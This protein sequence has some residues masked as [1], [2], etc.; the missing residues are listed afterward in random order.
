MACAGRAGQGWGGPRGRAVPQCCGASF[1]L[2]LG[3]HRLRATLT[4]LKPAAEHSPLTRLGPQHVIHC[5][6][7]VRLPCCCPSLGFGHVLAGQEQARVAWQVHCVCH[8][9]SAQQSLPWSGPL[10]GHQD[11]VHPL[12]QDL[13]NDGPQ[14]VE[15]GVAPHQVPRPVWCSCP[16]LSEHVHTHRAEAPVPRVKGPWYLGAE[17]V[18]GH[19]Q[20]R[21]APR[22]ALVPND[23]VV[24]L[25]AGSA[26]GGGVRRMRVVRSDTLSCQGRS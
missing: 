2:L 24:D 15:G 17:R 26:G 10:W 11:G 25:T 5:D 21:A 6:L 14:Q 19:V 12:I 22:E 18:C 20:C 16:R 23:G 3:S 1:P 7:V 8:R 13:P 4:C 9:Q